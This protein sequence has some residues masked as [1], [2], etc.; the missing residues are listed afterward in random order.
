[1][2]PML[3]WEV[4][5]GKEHCFVFFQA[6]AGFWEFDLVTGDELVIDCQSCFAGSAPGTFHGSVASLCPERFW[7]FYPEYWRSYEPSNAVERLGRILPAEQS[8]SPMIRHRCPAWV[9]PLDP[10]A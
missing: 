2:R 3:G 4:V 6:L 5:K 1:M 9:P 8:R 10:G 7:A